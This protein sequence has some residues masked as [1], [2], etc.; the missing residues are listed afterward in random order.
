MELLRYNTGKTDHLEIYNPDIL[1]RRIKKYV[2]AKYKIVIAM[3]II[4]ILLALFY[5]PYGI[6]NKECQKG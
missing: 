3:F 1:R 5:E 6:F 4:I 2:S